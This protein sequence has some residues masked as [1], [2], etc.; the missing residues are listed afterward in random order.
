MSGPGADRPRLESPRRQTTAETMHVGFLWD[1]SL[2]D[3]RGTLGNPYG[4]L[5]V[6]A[7]QKHGLTFERL[8]Y[9]S[10]PVGDRD[11]AAV[12]AVW[13]WR[14]R[15]RVRLLHFHW[16]AGFYAANR[17]LGAWLRLLRF[18]LL[19]A[20]ARLLGYRIV[21]TLHNLLPHER[22]HRGV[23]VASRFALA[24]L[25]HA[26]ICHCEYARRA[27]RRRFWRRRNIHVIP[28]GSFMAPYPNQ[29]SRAE[30]R[31]RLGLPADAFV[32][33]AF[34][35]IR[36]YKGHQDLCVAFGRLPGDD[37]R[38]LIAGQIHPLYAGAFGPQ[39]VHDPRVL[40][41]DGKVP[42]DEL[43]VYFNAADVAVFAYRDALT[44]G[45]LI[46]ALGFAKPVI[47]SRV[48]CIPELLNTPEIGVL[49]PPG[50]VAALTG[51]MRAARD[52]D[53][54]PRGAAA[55]ARARELDWDQIALQTLAAYGRKPR[56]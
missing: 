27:F 52:W 36:G 5:L 41:H 56:P 32:F 50:D 4:G 18:S 11:A 34:G 7:L 1:A 3:Y 23:D 15:G 10:A 38:L 40:W 12:G 47:A 28:H 21:W 37:L 53:L 8:E 42:I 46:N 25:A 16:T 30:A 33:V 19:V 24:L 43:Q 48:G 6:E 31:E 49:V 9:R 22:P 17:A 20:F 13:L 44:S 2:F 29:I 54:A 26:I 14:N 39:A 55:Q 51:A 45:A 35:N